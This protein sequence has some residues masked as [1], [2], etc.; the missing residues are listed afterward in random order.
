MVS[1]ECR[2]LQDPLLGAGEGSPKGE[3]KGGFSSKETSVLGSRKAMEELP[4]SREV[5]N[6]KRGSRR[7]GRNKDW[8]V[9]TRNKGSPSRRT[10]LIA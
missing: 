8:G 3:V 2:S 6:L 5:R 1:G 9:C 7:E 4:E 10:S